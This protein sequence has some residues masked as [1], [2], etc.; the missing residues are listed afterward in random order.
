MEYKI[1]REFNTSKVREFYMEYNG[2]SY[3]VIYGKHINGGFIAV[4][5]HYKCCEAGNT[6]DVFY[7]R[8]RLES[9]GFDKKTA[10]AIAMAIKE[11]HAKEEQKVES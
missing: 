6:I 5:N 9:C 11:F 3:L 2:Y 4:P 7:N 8:E 10:K 1:K